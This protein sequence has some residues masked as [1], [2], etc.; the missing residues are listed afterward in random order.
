LISKE[1]VKNDCIRALSTEQPYPTTRPDQLMSKPFYFLHVPRSCG[2][3]IV[4]NLQP[5]IRRCPFHVL[6]GNPVEEGSSE[7]IPFWEWNVERQWGFFL[8]APVICNERMLGKEFFPDRATYFT[9]I[10]DP[11]KVRVSIVNKLIKERHRDSIGS[12][13]IDKILQVA[14]ESQDY[15]PSNLITWMT[16]ALVP[17]ETVTPSHLTIA[18]Q[19]LSCFKILSPFTIEADFNH[20]FGYSFDHDLGR[21]AEEYVFDPNDETLAEAL[22]GDVALDKILLDQLGYKC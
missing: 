6:N 5:L 7:W 16:S 2:T 1:T 9:C 18:C 3:A 10:R 4:A 8:D 22:E 19:R 21:H 13:S 11:L 12:L 17:T 14:K 20:L 15:F